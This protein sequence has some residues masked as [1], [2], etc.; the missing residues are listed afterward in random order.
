[1]SRSPLDI[2]LTHTE[3]WI[4]EKFISECPEEFSSQK[5]KLKAQIKRMPE[6][7]KRSIKEDM[8]EALRLKVNIKS[9]GQSILRKNFIH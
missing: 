6:L 5:V 9:L 8:K 4:L 3:Y 7:Y 2:E 1:M